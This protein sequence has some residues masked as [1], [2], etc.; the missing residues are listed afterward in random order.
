MYILYFRK[1]SIIIYASSAFSKRKQSNNFCKQQETD[2][3]TNFVFFVM[4]LKIMIKMYVRLFGMVKFLTLLI[5][6]GIVSLRYDM[7][8]KIRCK[9]N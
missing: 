8:Q 1:L 3:R 4:F 9:F 7:N 2:C 6:L 5:V